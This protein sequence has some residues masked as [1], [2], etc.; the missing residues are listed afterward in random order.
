MSAMNELY[1]LLSKLGLSEHAITELL[2][3]FLR[4]EAFDYVETMNELGIDI[5]DILDKQY[6]A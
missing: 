2:A 5:D 3:R 1:D 6:E 4:E